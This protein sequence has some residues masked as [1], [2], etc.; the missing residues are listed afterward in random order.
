MGHACSVGRDADRTRVRGQVPCIPAS[1]VRARHLLHAN[2]VQAS[3]VTIGPLADAGGATA[4]F[5]S[6]PASTVA[7]QDITVRRS[8]DDGASWLA[9]TW[10]VQVCD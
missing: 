6:N 5:F 1:P 8:N 2:A 9:G 10:L 7:R 3:M 4:V